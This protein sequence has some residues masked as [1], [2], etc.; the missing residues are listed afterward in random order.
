MAHFPGAVEV[1]FAGLRIAHQRIHRAGRRRAAADRHAVNKGRDARD[2]FFREIE[3][4]HALI[5]PAVLHDRGD[6]FAIVI[7]QHQ[8]A[9]DQIGA[10]FAAAGI[11]SMAEAAI[12]AENLTAALNHGRV[13]RRPT[14]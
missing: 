7:V 1:G 2:F 10:A 13:G 11:R 6:E 9:A 5:R 14:G 8:F 12:R 3:L 4:R